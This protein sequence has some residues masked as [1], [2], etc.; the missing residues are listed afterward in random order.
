MTTA[1]ESTDQAV[2]VTTANHICTIALNRPD[3]FNAVNTQLGKDL[4]EA[5]DR[6]EADDDVRVIILTGKGKAFCSGQDLAELKD[7]YAPGH[8]PDLGPLLRDRYNLIATAI[9]SMGKPVIAAVNGIAAGAGCTLALTC[10][11]RIASADAEFMH[12]FINVGLIPDT[13][14]TYTLPRLIGYARA[15]EL[16]CTGKKIDA[17][18]AERIG[19]INKVVP[20]DQLM[21]EAVRLAGRL[22]KLPGRGIA[23][24]K[25]LLQQSL[26]NDLATQLEAE[27][28]A[29]ATAGRT[30]DHTE[31]VMAFIEKRKP[32]F[33]GK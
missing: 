9:C 1:A 6:A 29:Q 33:A 10:D 3:V 21:P 20:H 26:Q 27:A 7:Q 19:L 4:L 17:T 22:A 5:L 12:A 15:M 25:G 32:D 23:L 28:E 11:M 14:G 18:E 8:V 31:G 30:A 2:T 16:C 13:A 24:T